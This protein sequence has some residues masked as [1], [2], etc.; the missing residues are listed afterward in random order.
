MTSPDFSLIDLPGFLGDDIVAPIFTDG[1][2]LPTLLDALS[3]ASNIAGQR[4]DPASRFWSTRPRPQESTLREV[5]EV[6]LSGQ[7]LV[8]RVQFDLPNF[9]HEARLQCFNGTIWVDVLDEGGYPVVRTLRDS[10]PP[11]LSTQVA[12]QGLGHP[13]H[14]GANHWEHFDIA[15]TQTRTDRFRLLLH[16]IGVGTGPVDRLGVPVDYSL[17]V[18]GFNVGYRV[19]TRADI[20]AD[21]PVVAASYNSGVLGEHPPFASTVDILGS[22]V[23]YSLRER[24][25]HQLEGDGLWKCEPQ[26]INYSVI[27]LYADLTD[28]SGNPAIIDRLYLEPLAS[29]PTLNIYTTLDSDYQDDPGH[30]LPRFTNTRWTPVNRD[31]RLRRGFYHLL[32]T[33]ARW[34]KLEFSNLTPEPYESTSPVIRTVRLF[35]TDVLSSTKNVISG[36]VGNAGLSVMGSLDAT[37]RFR[38]N[39]RPSQQTYR[40][41]DSGYTPTEVLH[42]NDPT[43]AD[44]LRELSGIYNF[45]TWHAS[46]AQPRFNFTR[47]HSYIE[48]EI[49]HDQRVAYYVG[50][51]RFE[52]FRLDY[53]A[54]DDTDQYLDL[55]FDDFAVQS[56]TGWI[57]DDGDMRSPSSGT[58]PWVLTS[59]VFQSQSPVLGVQYAT[60]QT[61]AIQLLSDT[62]FDSAAVGQAQ[63]DQNWEGVGDCTGPIPSTDYNSDIG[64][65]VKV[66]RNQPISVT[67]TFPH[68]WRAIERRYHTWNRINGQAT[69]GDLNNANPAAQTEGGIA[70]TTV[71]EPSSGSRIYAATR[72]ISPQALVSPLLVQIYDVLSG[73]V[74]AEAEAEIPANQIVEWFCSYSQGD[75]AVSLKARLVQKGDYSGPWN[76]D[77]L[78][79]FEESIKWEFSNDGGN[80]FFPSF[81]TRN[82]ANG[83]L[84]FPQGPLATTLN[85]WDDLEHKYEG[86]VEP[87]APTYADYQ[88][89]TYYSM[90]ANPEPVDAPVEN[91]FVWRVSTSSTDQH[92]NGLSIR[93]WYGGPLYEGG[94]PYRDGVQMNGAATAL[95]DHYQPIEFDPRYRVWHKPIPQNWFFFYR[96]FIL[97]HGRGTTRAVASSLYLDDDLRV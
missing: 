87:P 40:N 45:H 95:Y 14:F 8:N 63:L 6:D 72:V 42:T 53:Q 68:T 97:G 88:G 81:L 43:A 91:L 36:N 13:Q 1:T 93:P 15:L 16:R 27:P 86:Y 62:D 85:T 52:V 26:P 92:V 12:Q 44:R 80:T 90:Q 48:T 82:D 59:K 64:T 83:V 2:P 46:H 37:L 5:M 20:P 32:P 9:P 54:D 21:D 69:Y 75:T 76:V 73:T 96:Q 66:V 38:D 58:G 31:F 35:P 41:D 56:N 70:S 67:T 25:S 18:R 49:E 39:D 84:V 77:T 55:F 17:G 4:Q 30:A 79:M 28:S 3:R 50:L 74:V 19:E 78:S 24:D 60:T 89:Q 61:P 29:G 65:S 10:N 23:A 47:T 33:K 57:I 22:T 51:R 11:V 7:K 34:I 94:I 71:I